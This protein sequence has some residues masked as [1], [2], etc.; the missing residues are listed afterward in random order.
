MTT[1]F[2]DQARAHSADGRRYGATLAADL[3]PADRVALC[4]DA[5]GYHVTI[6]FRYALAGQWRMVGTVA[7][8]ATLVGPGM[9]RPAL[10]VLCDGGAQI[11]SLAA[12]ASWSRTL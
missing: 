10:V 12:I 6:M 7:R 2:N 8:V 11:V 9:S 4:V 3:E 5:V 1:T